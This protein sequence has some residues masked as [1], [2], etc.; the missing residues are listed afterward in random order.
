[1]LIIIARFLIYS[2]CLAASRFH[3]WECVLHREPYEVIYIRHASMQC[4]AWMG[5][6]VPVRTE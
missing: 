2:M 1:M 3:H 6:T 4:S 5:V